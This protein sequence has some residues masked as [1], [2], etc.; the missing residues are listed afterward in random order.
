M[1]SKRIKDFEK[2]YITQSGDVYSRNY[3]QTGRIVKLVPVKTS[4]SYLQVM[5][6]NNKKGK[7][8]YVHR[9]VAEAFI[10]NPENKPQINHK[11]GIKTDN[12]VE[13]LEWVSCKENIRHAFDVLKHKVI[14]SM[15]GRFGKNHNRSKVVIQ[16]KGGK[17][18]NKFYGTAEASRKTG[19]RKN[20]ISACCRG[21]YKTA[22]GFIWK[23]KG[24]K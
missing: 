1:K 3:K 12:R 8:V 24:D 16:L 17:V 4:N 21:E 15:L 14:G 13:N 23:Y 10:P 22:G 20:S 19:V 5:L 7:F 9:L 11:N 18:I 2:Y 6:Y